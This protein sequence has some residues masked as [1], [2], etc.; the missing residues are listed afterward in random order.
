MS[1]RELLSRK[2]K[3]NNKH[4]FL[5]LTQAQLGKGCEV[6]TGRYTSNK[7]KGTGSLGRQCSQFWLVLCWAAKHLLEAFPSSEHR[8][9]FFPSSSLS[10]SFCLSFH[11]NIWV[12]PPEDISHSSSTH[13]PPRGVPQ[14]AAPSL[15]ITSALGCLRRKEWLS[16]TAARLTFSHAQPPL[17]TTESPEVRISAE[18]RML[19][20]SC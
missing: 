16:A 19:L 7:A 10:L 18:F 6:H 14:S 11:L 8:V 20:I 3:N 5:N 12:L 2:K 4:A 17:N 1:E 9:F 15:S 13:T